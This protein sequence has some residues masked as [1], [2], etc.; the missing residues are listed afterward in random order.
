MKPLA[1]SMTKAVILCAL[2]CCFVGCSV[3]HGNFTVASNKVFRLSQFE[4]EKANRTK[5]VEGESVQHTIFIFP[6]GTNPTIEGAMDDAML[7]GNGDVMTDVNISLWSFYIPYLYGQT[8]WSV[9]GD[10]VKTRKN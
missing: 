8:G 9:K 5:G 1:V 4:M 10:V 6:V 3:N 2:I 7:K